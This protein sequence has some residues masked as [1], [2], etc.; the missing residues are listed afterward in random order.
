MTDYLGLDHPGTQRRRTGHWAWL[1]RMQPSQANS[2]HRRPAVLTRQL[3]IALNRP[4]RNVVVPE[5]G[6]RLGLRSG[7]STRCTR[8]E[9]PAHP[10]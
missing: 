8:M 9:P 7:I 3:R 1:P 6:P 5:H 10:W 2:W 4:D